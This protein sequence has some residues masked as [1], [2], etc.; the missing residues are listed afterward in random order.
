MIHRAVILAT[1]NTIREGHLGSIVEP[2]SR[3]EFD[4]PQTSREL[5][6]VKKIARQKS[7]ENIERQFVLKA[8]ERSEWNVTKAATDTGMQRSNFQALMHKYDIHIRK[9][10]ETSGRFKV[11]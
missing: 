2:K 3:L 4:V 8:L 6:E 9:I 5:K 1:E 10:P 7:V 11:S